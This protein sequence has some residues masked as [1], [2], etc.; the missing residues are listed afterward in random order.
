MRRG[1]GLCDVP[2][3]LIDAVRDS[4]VNL[5]DVSITPA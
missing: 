3:A 1:F 5:M 4:Q 2:E